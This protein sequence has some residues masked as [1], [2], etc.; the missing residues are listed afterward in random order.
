MAEFSE[1][2]GPDHADAVVDSARLRTALAELDHRD[3]EALLL[4]A[5]EG[6]DNR[7]AARAMGCSAAT[8][9]VRL[10][11]ARRRLSRLLSDAAPLGEGAS[12]ADL[13]PLTAVSATSAK[14]M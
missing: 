8:F 10:Y 7:A 2:S 12:A 3:R 13:V 4:V 14:E 6:L 1:A 9:R 11:R 5:W